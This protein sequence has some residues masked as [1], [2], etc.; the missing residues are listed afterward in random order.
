MIQICLKQ[1]NFNRFKI[2]SLCYIVAPCRHLGHQIDIFFLMGY[3]KDVR[4][5][6]LRLDE[7]HMNEVGGLGVTEKK[8]MSLLEG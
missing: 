2:D 4:I 3:E 6:G 5:Q 8:K 1:N 7:G